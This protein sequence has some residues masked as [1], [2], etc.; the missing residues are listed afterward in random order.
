MTLARELEELADEFSPTAQMRE[1]MDV[2][3]ELPAPWFGSNARV[4]GGPA[5]PPT[6]LEMLSQSGG[7]QVLDGASLLDET[8]T[9]DKIA[10]AEIDTVHFAATA[11]IA[12]LTNDGAD[13]VIDAS[14]LTIYDGR[15][16]IIDDYGSVVMT[17][18][19]FSGS[20]L[21]FLLFGAYNAG[22]RA[23]P[24]TP[25][26]NITVGAAGQNR[27]PGWVFTQSTGTGVT[28]KWTADTTAPMGAK[29]RMSIASGIA[30][31][32]GYFTQYIPVSTSKSRTWTLRPKVTVI[33]SSVGTAGLAKA[34]IWTQYYK[35]DGITPT[36]S[37][38]MLSATLTQINAAA[39]NTYEL[40]I[41]A[42]VNGMI[43]ADAG[44]L[45]VDVG[46]KRDTAANS[47]A[48]SVDFYEVIMQR[49]EERL[50]LTDEANPTTY[51]YALI[52]QVEGTLYLR[53]DA[54][55]A[56]S[57]YSYV[58]IDN[59]GDIYVD[60]QEDLFLEAALSAQLA[61]N[62][63]IYITADTGGIYVS[64]GAGLLTL[65]GPAPEIQL[66]QDGEANLRLFL[67]GAYTANGGGVGFG[68]GGG[69]APDTQLYRRR[70]N[71]LA[72]GDHLLLPQ[73]TAPPTPPAGFG[74]IYVASAGRLRYIDDAG[75]DTAL[76]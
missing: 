23:A 31:D 37:S 47:A 4:P 59:D 63:D 43:P 62:N 20:W 12:L 67:N 7:F 44:Y 29:N 48:G 60:S 15:F 32:E 50:M 56:I 70:A 49:A 28:A 38:S 1:F 52:R 55:S 65:E 54:Q 45:R 10:V 53:A 2:Y 19:G 36:G 66:W 35:A 40:S 30:G 16:S 13:V 76:S 69:T 46:L 68:P 5:T 57:P 21:D 6:A 42:N 33:C 25:A 26:N 18:G 51:S 75:V 27:M 34:Y 64:S 3:S 17:G 74:M 72:V 73:I 11:T 41:A 9:G 39:S 58:S 24:P 8:V 14:G 61:V 22:W 71:G